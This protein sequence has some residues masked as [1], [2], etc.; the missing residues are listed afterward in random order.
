LGIY[1]VMKQILSRPEAFI[2][3]AV[4]QVALPRMLQVKDDASAIRHIYLEN[5]FLILKLNLPIYIFLLLAAQPFLS[6]LLGSPWADHADVFRWL[7]AFYMIHSAFN[8][9]GAL[10]MAKGRADLGFYFNLLLFVLLPC[11]IYVG[12]FGGLAGVAMA[13]FLLFLCLIPVYYQFFL[14]PM[15]K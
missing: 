9:I 14:L 12:T 3:P 15:W 8:P 11:A 6:C 4:C 2:N 1:D 5:L 13:L 7:I 10:Q